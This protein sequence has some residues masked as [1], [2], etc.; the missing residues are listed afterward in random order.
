MEPEDSAAVERLARYI[1]RP[2]ISL[3]RM[4]WQGA[5][6]VRYRAR[7]GH[8]SGRGQGREAEELFDPREFLAR[9]L[10][11]VPEPRRHLVRYYGAYSNAARGR[12]RRLAEGTRGRLASAPGPAQDDQESCEDVRLFRRRWR[13]LIKRIYEV[14]PLVCPRCHAEMRIIAFIIDHGV[15]DKI[16]RHLERKEIE[17][18]RGPPEPSDLEAAS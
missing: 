13:E 6:P 2:P 9:V 7:L 10:M 1:M 17:R 14:D 3:E 12:R 11:H 4:D 16:L 18:E 15:V 8:A 5:G